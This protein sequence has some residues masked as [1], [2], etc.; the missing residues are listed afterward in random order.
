MS[1]KLRSSLDGVTLMEEKLSSLLEVG[2]QRRITF[3]DQSGGVRARYSPPAGFSLIDF[4]QH[5][6]GPMRRLVANV[7]NLTPVRGGLPNDTEDWVAILADFQN[8][9]TGVM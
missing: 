3:L 4:A 7:K 9:A 5:L 1:R 8:G 6:I 2:P